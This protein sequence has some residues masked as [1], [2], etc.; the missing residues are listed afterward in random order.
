MA[1]NS[2][3]KKGTPASAASAPP[4]HTAATATMLSFANPPMTEDAQ[5]VAD[6][7]ARQGFAT[8]GVV[9]HAPSDVIDFAR[10]DTQSCV[11]LANSIELCVASKGFEVPSLAGTF[12]VMREQGTQ[13]T[14]ANFVKALTKIMK[15]KS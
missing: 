9:I 3:K 11:D 8:V 1:S 15:P 4:V 6:E 5:Q 10:F 12:D 7:C 14:F 2:S 13:I